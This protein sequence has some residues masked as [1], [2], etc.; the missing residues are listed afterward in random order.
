V[1]PSHP[2]F[3]L[4]TNPTLQL[5]KAKLRLIGFSSLPRRPARHRNVIAPPRAKRNATSPDLRFVHPIHRHRH[6]RA[7]AVPTPPLKPILTFGGTIEAVRA[8]R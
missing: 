7:T 5:G 6:R 2:T 4:N 1:H 3:A 8:R